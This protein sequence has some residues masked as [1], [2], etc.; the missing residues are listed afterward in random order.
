MCLGKLDNGETLEV[1]HVLTKRMGGDDRIINL[2]MLHATCHEQVHSQQRAS[3][4][5]DVSKLRE[6]YAG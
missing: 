6:P 3:P 1:H 4:T 2:A 5:T